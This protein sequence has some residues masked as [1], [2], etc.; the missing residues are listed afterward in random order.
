MSQNKIEVTN[1]TLK[2]GD[3]LAVDNV[4]FHL[5]E[6]ECLTILGANGAGKSSIGKSLAGLL[7]PA[8]GTI[9]LDGDEIQGLDP[10]LIA[11]RGLSY[12][13]EGRAIFPTLSVEENLMLGARKLSADPK[14]AVEH[15]Y[16]L[17]TRLGDRRKQIARTLSGGEQQM[18]AVAKALITDPQVLVVDEL[19]L[20]LAPLI[21]EDIYVALAQARER[22]NV[23]IVLIEQYIDRALSFA[24]RAML[25]VHGHEVWNGPADSNADG[26]VRGFLSGESAA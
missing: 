16:E 20:G 19:S 7:P 1:L 5:A 15:A 11:Q 18:L 22:N 25:M 10:Y 23:T 26:I 24:D 9:A 2:Y 17:F 13:P 3:A 4:S 12:L 14:A 6:G 21:I 8:S